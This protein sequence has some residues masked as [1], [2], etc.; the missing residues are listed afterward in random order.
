MEISIQFLGDYFDITLLLRLFQWKTLRENS[1]PRFPVF[2]SIR[3][4]ESKET[5][6]GQNKKYNL[7]FRDCFPLIFFWKATLSCGKLKRGN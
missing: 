3:K 1:F 2:V 6:F 7:F 4:N 5:I